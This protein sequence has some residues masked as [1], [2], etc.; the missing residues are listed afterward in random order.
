MNALRH[1]EET[2]GR[3]GKSLVSEGVLGVTERVPLRC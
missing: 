3:L 2:D 1:R